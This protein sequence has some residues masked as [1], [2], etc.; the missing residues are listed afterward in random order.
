MKNLKT[1]GFYSVAGLISLFAFPMLGVIAPTLMLCGIVTPLAG[2][3]KFVGS[4]FGTDMSFIVFQIGNLILNPFLTFLASI[5]TGF[6]LFTVGIMA[7]KL[8]RK[9]LATVSKIKEVTVK[10]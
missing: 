1:F 4:I 6:V 7:W 8:L 3:V 5:I 9:Y 10:Q 2:L